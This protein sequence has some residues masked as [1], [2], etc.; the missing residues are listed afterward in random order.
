MSG[1]L[2]YSSKIVYKKSKN[3][4]FLFLFFLNIKF[5]VIKTSK[6]QKKKVSQSS[7]EMEH[8]G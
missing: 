1:R 8:V 3:Q 6:K 5:F 7:V 4:S 2:E